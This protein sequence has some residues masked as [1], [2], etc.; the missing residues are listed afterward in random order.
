MFETGETPTD[1]VLQMPLAETSLSDHLSQ[2]GGR[3][4][5]EEAVEVLSDVRDAL[6]HLDARVVHRDLK[7]QNVLR[8]KGKWCIADFGIARCAAESTDANTRKFAM[9]EP[10]AAPE[11]WRLE[12]AVA[13]TD[14]YSFGVMAHQLL[15]GTLPFRGPD[16]RH[17]HLHDNPPLLSGVSPQIQS[18]VLDCL[19]KASAAR[20]NARNL[21]SRLVT[22]LT[23]PSAAASQLQGVNANVAAQLVDASALASARRSE[24][25]RRNELFE[26]AQAQIMRIVS[27]LRSQIENNASSAQFGTKG[28]L[29]VRLGSAFL[30]V[31]ALQLA[32]QGNS[33]VG[34]A[35]PPFDVIA[36]TKITVK[37]QQPS[38]GYEGRQHS[39]WYGD[40]PSRSEYRWLE[41]AFCSHALVS[42]HSP[43][44]NPFALHPDQDAYL[45]LGNSMHSYVLARRICTIDQGDEMAFADRWIEWL[46]RAAMNGLGQP[47]S[48]PE[49]R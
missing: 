26:T 19:S 41:L 9:T 48:M 2:S 22:A 13:A 8:Y 28:L 35:Q 32:P 43:S 4:A 20:P 30:S 31:D 36:H 34:A 21:R 18:L 39:L 37:Q 24:L 5:T 29:E 40:S 49:D 16:F 11:R 25:E 42:L 14:I 23:S 1:W 17:Q 45:A 27:L 3:L 7:P 33:T 46:S 38:F 6:A 15:S 47:S 44:I 12:R 10:Y